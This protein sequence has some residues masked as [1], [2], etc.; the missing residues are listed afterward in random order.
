LVG[1]SNWGRYLEGFYE[2]EWD[3]SDSDYQDSWGL[4]LEER[5]QFSTPISGLNIDLH[6]GLVTG[7]F[8][9]GYV[10]SGIAYS[11]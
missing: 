9:G 11:F 6:A 10:G 2:D 5:L 7:E 1:L 4:M 8:G 3:Y